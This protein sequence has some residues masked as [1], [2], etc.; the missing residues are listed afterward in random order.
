MRRRMLALLCVV[1]SIA[2]GA[3]VA[4]PAQAASL[5]VAHVA[6]GSDAAQRM[7]VFMP[8]SP[9]P[10]PAVLFIH[11]GCWARSR[12]RAVESSIAREIAARSGWVVGLMS[13][14]VTNERF[15]TMPADVSAALN[16]LQ[17]GAFG[18]EASRVALWGESA[19]GQL[20]LLTAY[21]SHGKP[22]I[23]RPRAVVSVSGPS[24]ML[25]EYPNLQAPAILR[26]VQR[27]EGGPPTTTRLRN[28]Y[29]N[30]SPV[31][32]VD[33]SD[34]A[35]MLVTS[36]GDK[37]VR[38]SQQNELASRLQANAVPNRILTVQ[39]QGHATQLEHR[40]TVTGVTVLRTVLQFL[41]P[42]LDGKADL[43]SKV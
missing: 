18:V 12:V 6:Y 5:R 19:G 37:Y 1:G 40:K 26:C 22:G 8:S 21:R 34:P 14:R 32:W 41:R 17:T 7:T 39:G 24:D 15:R 43:L 2:A 25:T 9:G 42:Y 35:T 27:F 4:K 30:T 20:A 28:R 13:Y 23:G 16:R 31:N 10:H 11:G 38:A 29:V 33:G 3:V 36:A